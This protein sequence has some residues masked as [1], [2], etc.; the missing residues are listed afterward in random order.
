MERNGMPG[1][2]YLAAMLGV[3]ALIAIM[4]VPSLFQKKCQ[5]CD[6]RNSLDARVCSNCGNPFPEDG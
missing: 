5:R 6:T 4:V 2:T 3:I 1:L